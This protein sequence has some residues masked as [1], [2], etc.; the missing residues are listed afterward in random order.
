M[1]KI[2][3]SE[4]FPIVVLI[5]FNLGIGVLLF[6]DYGESWDEQLRY[7]Y[8]ARSLMAYTG[9]DK[10]L[11]DEKGAFYVMIAKLGSDVLQRIDS[12]L[13]PIEAW[14]F[15]HFLSFVLGLFFLYRLCLN[16]LS[17]TA[18]FG[19]VLLFNTQP[20]LWGHAFI[21]PKDIPFMAF[22]LGSF[23]LG[24]ELVENY[25]HRA[26]SPKRLRPLEIFRLQSCPVC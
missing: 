13:N 2:L 19:T 18:A 12:G 7:N 16:F 26:R 17:K 25:L 5:I 24:F 14:H 10:S 1:W 6:N 15:I 4:N 23:A 3:A 22:F 20:L 11:I 8:A 9:A 21:N